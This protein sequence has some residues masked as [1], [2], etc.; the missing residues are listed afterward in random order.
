LGLAVP[1]NQI[2]FRVA[3]S[4]YPEALDAHLLR[5]SAGE[6]VVTEYAGDDI[7]ISFAPVLVDRRPKHSSVK[8]TLSP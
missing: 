2:K 3:G 6:N 8:S 1:V 4:P 7:E 5:Q